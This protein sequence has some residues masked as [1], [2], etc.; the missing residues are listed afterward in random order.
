MLTGMARGLSE[1]K[2]VLEG[3]VWAAGIV[4]GAEA[5]RRYRIRRATETVGDPEIVCNKCGDVQRVDEFLNP[6]TTCL[7]VP[8]NDVDD[9]HLG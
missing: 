5:Y 1:L 6:G 2:E 7:C 3:A 4:A 9:P 8:S